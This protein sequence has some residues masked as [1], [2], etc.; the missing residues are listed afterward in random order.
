MNRVGII[1]LLGGMMTALP[2]AAAQGEAIRTAAEI[3][4]DLL[5]VG[6]SRTD[7]YIGLSQISRQ[8]FEIAAGV[9]QRIRSGARYRQVIGQS[10]KMKHARGRAKPL[11]AR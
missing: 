1:T 9:A 2:L 7:C 11:R 3:N 8:E 5:P 10:P 4:C 6:P